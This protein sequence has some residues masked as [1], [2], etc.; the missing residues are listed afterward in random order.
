MDALVDVRTIRITID[1]FVSILETM[2]SQN[3]ENF[4]QVIDLSGNV[5]LIDLKEIASHIT[6]SIL[7]T[8]SFSF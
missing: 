6:N 5:T 7:A 4:K 1:E 8:F 2:K 3:I